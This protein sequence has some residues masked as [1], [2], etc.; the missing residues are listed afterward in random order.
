MRRKRIVCIEK[1]PTHH[2]RHHHI[3]HVGVGLEGG[4]AQERLSTEEVIAQ[5]KNP[6]GDRFFVIGADGAEAEVIYKDCPV[7]GLGHQFITTTPDHTKTDNL[8]SLREC[9]EEECKLS[10]HVHSHQ[11]PG[12]TAPPGPPQPPRPPRD[13]GVG[14]SRP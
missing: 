3:T 1:K 7:C 11:P 13:R 8:L 9:R 5:L 6:A 2:D 12:P 10:K 4:K 14:W